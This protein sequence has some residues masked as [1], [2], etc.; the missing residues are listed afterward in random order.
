MVVG[1][2]DGLRLS[3][4]AVLA[5]HYCNSTLL[6]WYSRR[7]MYGRISCIWKEKEM[8]ST[9]KAKF[10]HARPLFQSRE[11]RF[12]RENS[13]RGSVQPNIPP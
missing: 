3:L 2:T 13:K 6:H 11:N 9:Q 5:W 7:L 10:M 1:L 12:W 4:G 8:E